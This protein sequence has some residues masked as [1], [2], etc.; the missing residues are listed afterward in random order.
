MCDANSD[1]GV[2]VE[3]VGAVAGCVRVAGE[4]LRVRRRCGVVL[5]AGR[6]VMLVAVAGLVAGLEGQRRGGGERPGRVPLLAGLF[7]LLALQTLRPLNESV[8]SFHQHR[9]IV[10]PKHRAARRSPQIPD[11][12][13]APVARLVLP[14]NE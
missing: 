9:F 6:L 10:S 5:L 12:S 3:R 1:L 8:A 13:T 7:A 11:I 2:R 4:L 14:A